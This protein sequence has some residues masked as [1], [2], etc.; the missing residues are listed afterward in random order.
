[1]TPVIESMRRLFLG[2]PVGG[3]VWVATAWCAGLLATSVALSAVLFAR[4]MSSPR[5]AVVRPIAG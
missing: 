2:V 5:R 1:V 4:R 3:E